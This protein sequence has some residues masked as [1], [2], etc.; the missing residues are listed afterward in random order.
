MSCFPLRT[1]AMRANDATSQSADKVQDGVILS[2]AWRFT[3][4]FLTTLRNHP[5]RPPAFALRSIGP[6]QGTVAVQYHA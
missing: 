2:E 3:R 1:D 4:R 5:H 6:T